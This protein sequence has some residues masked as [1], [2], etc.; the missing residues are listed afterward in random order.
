[1][2]FKIISYFILLVAC[3]IAITEF[4]FDIRNNLLIYNTIIYLDFA[5][6]IIYILFVSYKVFNFDKPFFELEIYE[7]SE[8]FYF[9][10]VLVTIYYPRLSAG[11][12]I[13]RIFI[14]FLSNLF[15]TD[16]GTKVLNF[17]NKSPSK[18]LAIGFLSV[19]LVG[20]LLLMLPASTNDAK[21]ASFIN[22]LFTITSATCVSGLSVFENLQTYFTTFGQAVILF[23]ME[24][25]GLGVMVLSTIFIILLNQNIPFKKQTELREILNMSVSEQ[26]K[27][28]II[29][30]ISTA[31]II[32]SSA[33]LILFFFLKNKIHSVNNRFWWSLFHTVSSFCNVGLSLTSNSFNDF[34]YDSR[35]IW[36]FIIL[37]TLGGLGFFVINDLFVNKI[38]K[39]TNIKII[40]NR[41]HLQTKIVV[42][43]TIGVDILGLLLFLYFEYNGA[44]QNLTISEKINAS[45]F[46][47]VNLRSAGFTVV[48]I[49]SIAA[50]TI[51]F[52][53]VFMFIGASPGSTAGG[54][55]N[56]TAVVSL[57]ALFSMLKNRDKVEIMNRTISPLVV[58]RSLSILLSALIVVIVFLCFLLATQNIKFENLLFECISAFGNVGLSINTTM[59]LDNIGKFLIICV[60]YIG[61]IGPLTLVLAIA[62]KKSSYS[63]SLPNGKISVG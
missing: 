4:L 25:G 54:I 14:G 10:L 37:I 20:T 1:M 53:V 3:F 55:K 24:I 6:V 12:I 51:L 8:L 13:V 61:R 32:Q 41:L 7:K 22:A 27:K 2:K 56:T 46:Y 44:L 57:M 63:Y 62:Q 16:K 31:V 29:S 42:L 45:L 47:S 50:P 11:I 35:I 15:K 21:G 52:S 38:W 28:N 59:M 30:I 5:I 48:S 26:L 34:L 33:V 39:V 58:N 60:M 36:L 9:F 18:V 40:W 43:F 49:A 19:I 17:L 23:A